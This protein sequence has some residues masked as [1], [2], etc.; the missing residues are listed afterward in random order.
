MS[1]RHDGNSFVVVYLILYIGVA[2]YWSIAKAP[3]YVNLY[4]VGIN[5]VALVAFFADKQRAVRGEWRIPE[6]RLHLLTLAGGVLGSGAGMLLAHHK[7]RKLSFHAMYFLGLVTFCLITCA[8][9]P[10]AS[11]AGGSP[12]ASAAT[13]GSM[14]ATRKTH[15]HTRRH[16]AAQPTS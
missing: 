16:A 1:R 13:A 12:T 2:V 4:L 6:A 14:S 7:V 8:L 9:A 10:A 5:L 3:W 15:P 11:N